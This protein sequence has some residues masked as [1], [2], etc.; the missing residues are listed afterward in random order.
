MFPGLRQ[1][2]GSLSHGWSWFS[3]EPGSCVFVAMESLYT[4]LAGLGLEWSPLHCKRNMINSL[5]SFID[6]SSSARS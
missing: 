3:E 2:Q 4:I 5:S 1:P 6:G